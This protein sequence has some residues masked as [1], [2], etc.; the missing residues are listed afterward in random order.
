MAD[1]CFLCGSNQT[2]II[3]KGTRDNPTIDVLKCNCCGLVRLSQVADNPNSYYENSGMREGDLETTLDEIRVVAAV[4]DERRYEFVKR[5]A[6]NKSVLDFGCGAGG[7]LHRL[8][9]VS[10]RVYGVEIERVMCD[11]INEEGIKCYPS[12][13]KA[14]EELTDSIDI[15]TMFH[16]LEHIEDPVS[17]L[18]QLSSLLNDAGTIIIEVPNAEDALL[19]VYDSSA[20][21]DFTYWSAHL[22]LYNNDTLKKLIDKAGMRIQFMSQ[23]QRYPLSN[24][25]YWLA[26]GKPGGHKKWAM[27]S[28]KDLDREYERHLTGLGIADTIIAIVEKV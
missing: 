22:Y 14:C 6:E 3:H 5:M 12:I 28:N 19:S 20:F 27:L 9:K 23:V 11:A 21:A 8:N 15:I 18:K 24:T 1:T 7:V 17:I 2:K 10:S 16:V 25:L 13:D 4:D 26:K